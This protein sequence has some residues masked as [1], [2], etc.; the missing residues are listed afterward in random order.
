MR[1]RT[2]SSLVALS[3]LVAALALPGVSQASA[4]H[5]A[6]SS[7]AAGPPVQTYGY[8]LAGADR[9]FTGDRGLPRDQDVGLLTRLDQG[10]LSV[11]FA[12]SA[13]TEQ[14]LVALADP[15]RDDTWAAL[16]VHGGTLTWRVVVA[17][18]PLTDLRAPAPAAD[19]APHTVSVGV[20]GELTQISFDGYP[21]LLAPRGDF[22]D[23]VPA[24]AAWTFG[25]RTTPAGPAA[26]LTG[27]I[28]R[29][30]V[31][32][33]PL[34]ST[35][36]A[37][38][39][40][41]RVP[42]V[43]AD[44]TALRARL[45]GPA[46]QA[47]ETWVFTGD[48]ITHGAAHTRGFRS[49]SQHVEERLR[50]E[51]R[52]SGDQ[53][54][55][56]AISGDTAAGILA[57]W[58]ERVATHD[59]TVV[60]VM[61]G[62][63]DVVVLGGPAGLDT[64]RS[65]LTEIVRRTRALGAIPVLATSQPVQGGAAGTNRAAYPQYVQVVREVAAA[66][67]TVLVDNYARWTLDHAG[68]PPADLWADTIHP[69]PRGHLLLAR[70]FLDELGVGTSA[71]GVGALD[72]PTTGQ[73]QQPTEPTGG[74]TQAWGF[75]HVPSAFDGT[76]V[77][78]RS[79]DVAS[80]RTLDEGTLLARFAATAGT[81]GTLLSLSDSA[82]APGAPTALSLSLRE[83]RLEYAVVRD[84]RDLVRATTSTRFDDG[85]QHVAAAAVGSGVLTLYVDGSPVLVTPAR[86]FASAVSPDT[87]VVGG[88]RVGTTDTDRFTGTITRTWFVRERL[89][90]LRLT[91]DGAA[92]VLPDLAAVRTILTRADSTAPRTWLFAGDSITHGAQHT[93]GWRSWSQHVEERLRWERGYRH[94]YVVTTATSGA[95]AQDLVDGF[96]ARIGRHDA[97]VVT[98][99][100]GMN[101]SAGGLAGIPAFEENLRT[102]VRAV[103][104]DGA[105]PVLATSE[106]VLA[107]PAYP[108]YV[109]AVR[110]VAAA[111]RVFVVDTYAQWLVEDGGVVP[112]SWLADPIHPGPQGHV[113]MARTFLDGFGVWSPTSALASVSTVANA[114]LTLDALAPG[115]TTPGG[116]YQV[117][118]RAT[119][120]PSEARDVVL[121]LVAPPG[122]SVAAPPVASSGQ[123]VLGPDGAYR[124]VLPARTP[125]GTV[126]TV[127]AEI[128]VDARARPG[129]TLR[130]RLEGAATNS[131]TRPV[132]ATATTVVR[133][134]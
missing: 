64:F 58:D 86:E 83:G 99:M 133:T 90:P 17:G 36:L 112:T 29:V 95:R 116:R 18:Q 32:D 72:L 52:R 114:S 22:L 102:L 4:E 108:Q 12:T 124:V 16:G 111:E 120:G 94:D 7:A 30:T 84:G 14:T 87:L 63:N 39:L 75:N 61:V 97:D 73:I 34:T 9:V 38:T 91:L 76:R 69:G 27:T 92:V 26:T 125:A 2:L 60:A 56:T 53:M 35:E 25:A 74:A 23:D 126:V 55:N 71:S 109:Q 113:E 88:A 49:W 119:V 68:A 85:Q 80:V 106:P 45:A 115:S 31:H 6:T 46:A 44:A 33:R 51:L 128:Q 132:P 65:Q 93:A 57:T 107:R 82:A 1:R 24:A 37:S 129:A 130:T 13:A 43:R 101:D 134:P 40:V 98:V 20:V 50:W 118:A 62:M 100:I 28:D 127:S 54:V 70:A 15:T 89:T 67:G 110:D 5:P 66:Q 123:V 117:T 3:G 79:A 10:A 78:D 11:R 41:M 105:V 121:S 48:S 21:V 122:A 104:A 42:T 103:R 131:A 96:E 8:S 59:P 19:G 81:G 77:V 47:A